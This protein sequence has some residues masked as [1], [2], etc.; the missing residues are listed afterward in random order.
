MA[1]LQGTVIAAQITTGDTVN[2]FPVA[3]ANDI[4]GGLMSVADLTA[5]DAIPSARRRVGMEVFVAADGKTYQLYGGVANA[6]W[7]D[8][9]GG[10][11]GE[12]T[13]EAVETVLTGEILTHTHPKVIDMGNPWS[14]AEFDPT[15]DR[16]I[17][18]GGPGDL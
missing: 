6:N 16:D 14:I 10:G 17:D 11:G 15:Y 13:K 2:T 12:V 3:D 18:A 4:L 1:Q 8:R 5:R 9:P 7:R